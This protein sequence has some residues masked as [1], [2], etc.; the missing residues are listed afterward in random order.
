MLLNCILEFDY[1][2]HLN[3]QIQ[4]LKYLIEIGTCFAASGF[5][6]ISILSHD[7]QS[8]H[9]IFNIYRVRNPHFS[10]L[11]LCFFAYSHESIVHDTPSQ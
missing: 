7:R 6:T 4:I 3:L 9:D 2:I 5:P 1:S 10:K 8:C 11:E